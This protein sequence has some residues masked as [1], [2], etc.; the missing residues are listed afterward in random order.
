[1]D[2]AGLVEGMGSN[3]YVVGCAKRRAMTQKKPV[4]RTW[5]IFMECVSA[6]GVS[7]LPV[8][9]YKGANVQ[10]QWFPKEMGAYKGWYFT[11]TKKGWINDEIGLEWL[12]KRFLP[13]TKPTDPE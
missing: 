7:L 11:V 4:S 6:T 3:G 5:I 13:I 9:I 12:T 1:M 2:E 10:Q 8:V